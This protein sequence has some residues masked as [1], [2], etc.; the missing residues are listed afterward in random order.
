[1]TGRQIL[2]LRSL[3][4]RSKLINNLN[5]TQR[6]YGDCPPKDPPCPKEPSAEDVSNVKQAWC[7]VSRNKGCYGKA[8]FTEVFKKHP[9]YTTLFAK[10]GRCPTD[11]LKNEKFIEHLKKNVIDTMGNLI[12]KMDE[13]MCE[14]KTMAEEIGKKHVKLCVKPKHFE[15]TEKIFIDVLKKQM[16]D[17]L[18]CE[19]G[20]S[21]DTVIKVIFKSL[22]KGAAGCDSC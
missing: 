19:G 5:S 2:S 3:L 18:S 7:E 1:M 22:K 6:L 21:M 16:G 11:I 8:I 14:A 17:K 12:N 9:D 15:N 20:K 4:G 13:D 10:F